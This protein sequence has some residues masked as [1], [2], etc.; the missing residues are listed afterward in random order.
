MSGRENFP[1]SGPEVRNY[2]KGFLGASYSLWVL[3]P[4]TCLCTALSNVGGKS[5]DTPASGVLQAPSLAS[6][7]RQECQS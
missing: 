4:F 5:P 6:L 7:L 1:L 3:R 2:T